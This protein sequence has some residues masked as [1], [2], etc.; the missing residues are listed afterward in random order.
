MPL[1]EAQ[2]VRAVLLFVL[3]ALVFTGVAFA[4]E[5][6]F[7]ELA[8]YLTAAGAAAIVAFGFL[9]IAFS[10]G[11]AVRGHHPKPKPAVSPDDAAIGL[12]AGMA[13]DKPLLA[14]LFAGLLG[15]AGTILQHKNHVK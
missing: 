1:I 3:I 2:A 10:I 6:A 11:F 7:L 13:K 14:V 9:A 12:I 4:G 5:A 8:V 15:A